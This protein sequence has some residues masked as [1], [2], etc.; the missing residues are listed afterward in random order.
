MAEDM[1]FLINTHLADGVTREQVVEYFAREGVSPEAWELFR[2]R[3]LVNYAFKVGDDVGL[4]GFMNEESIEVARSK[5]EALPL[6]AEGYVNV[7]I[8]PLRAV[9]RFD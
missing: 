3:E 1:R 4:V 7:E 2:N 5:V 8:A 9:A 6:V